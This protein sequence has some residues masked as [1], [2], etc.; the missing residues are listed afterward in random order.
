[1]WIEIQGES[2]QRF[3]FRAPR[4]IVG[5]VH[6]E[7]RDIE[8]C[9]CNRGQGIARAGGRRDAVAGITEERREGSQDECIVIDQQ[10]RRCR[11]RGRRS[12]TCHRR[13]RG[14]VE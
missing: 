12:P 1:V 2:K 10:D 11:R 7:H 14:P 13:S 6:V 8:R 4:R 3:T 5:E 9:T